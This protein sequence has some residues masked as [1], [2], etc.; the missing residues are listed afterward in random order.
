MTTT[1]TTQL[2]LQRLMKRLDI[3][4]DRFMREFEPLMVDAAYRCFQCGR[5]DRCSVVLDSEA[6]VRA[7]LDICPN[8]RMLEIVSPL[9]VL[10]H[11]NS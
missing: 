11:S 9:P 1:D 5:R 8:L 3:D 7:I 10:L 4:T 6:P 2:P